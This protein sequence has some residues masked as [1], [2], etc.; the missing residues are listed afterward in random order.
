[1]KK[2]VIS[3]RAFAAFGATAPL[4]AVLAGCGSRAATKAA[5]SDAGS[6]AVERK[7]DVTLQVFAANSLQKAMP[8]VQGLY[9]EQTGVQFADTQFLASGDLVKKMAAGAES[10]AF[11]AASESSMDD[12]VSQDLVD[13]STRVDMFTNDLVVVKKKGSDLGISSLE[14]LADVD[15]KVSIGDA[16][17]VPAGKY[18]NQALHSVD[19]YTGT[20]GDDGRYVDSFAP[21]VDTVAKVGDA[22]AHVASG[23][24]AA[25]MVYSSDVYRFDGV[26]VAFTTPAESHKPIVYPGAVSRASKNAEQAADF[27]DFCLNNREAQKI[28]AKYG[29]ELAE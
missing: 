14:D 1:M 2:C 18:A 7:S 26:E 20:A 15:G 16:A 23:D 29:F 21:K 28:W 11:I 22:A 8:E 13:D 10:D 9:T 12:A 27:L 17:T 4:A 24:A 3:R 19:L 5:G 25:G 6:A